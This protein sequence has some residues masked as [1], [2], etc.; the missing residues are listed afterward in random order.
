MAEKWG[1]GWGWRRRVSGMGA[2]VEESVEEGVEMGDIGLSVAAEY[3]K[4]Y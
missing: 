2:R 3:D 1:L 4:T